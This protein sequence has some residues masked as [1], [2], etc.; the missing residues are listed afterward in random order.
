M[1]KSKLNKNIYFPE[2]IWKYILKFTEID[3]RWYHVLRYEKYISFP[4]DKRRQHINELLS[5][6]ALYRNS[7]QGTIREHAQVCE[8]IHYMI[9]FNGI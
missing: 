2:D 3:T 1:G 9:L 6:L 8:S 4:R 7:Y 5:E